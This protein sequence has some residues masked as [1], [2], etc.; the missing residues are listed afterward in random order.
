MNKRSIQFIEKNGRREW[1]ILPYDLFLTL[2]DEHE[3]LQDIKDFDE[4]VAADD[5]FRVPASIAFRIADGEHP[6]KVWREHHDMTLSA[7][8]DTASISPAYLSQIESGKRQGTLDVLT[9]ICDALEI[10][11]DV[12]RTD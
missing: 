5:G 1:A 7:L 11:L 8:A 2:A 12:L 10:P 6:I 3:S 4:A 9:A